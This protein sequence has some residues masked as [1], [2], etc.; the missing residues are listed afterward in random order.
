MRQIYIDGNNISI[1]AD[2]I[3][4]SVVCYEG[5]KKKFYDFKNSK[6]D[7]EFRKQHI[8]IL[9]NKFNHRLCTFNQGKQLVYLIN[10]IR[11]ISKKY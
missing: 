9:S 4:K 1:H 8:A 5:N 10:K 2:L 11:T 6:R 7:D 3:N